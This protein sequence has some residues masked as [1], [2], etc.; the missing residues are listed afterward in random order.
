MTKKIAIYRGEG[1]WYQGTVPGMAL[2]A[3]E[4][5]EG[6]WDR[7]AS[8]FIMPGGRDRL[9]HADL[10]GPGNQKIRSFVEKGGT[11]LGI[12][13]GA[14]YGCKKI[15]F[16]RDSPLEICEERELSFFSGTA[17][18]PAYGTGT[19]VYGCRKGV[20]A[21]LIDSDLGSFHSYHY[22]GCYFSGD[23]SSCRVLARYMEIPGHP[24]AVIECSVGKGKAI[25]SGVH[26]EISDESGDPQDPHFSSIA[27]FLQR[28]EK[29]RIKFWK[30]FILTENRWQ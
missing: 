27:P 24:P 23:F 20:R 10:K 9:Y 19:Y 30:K 14:Y 13:A 7:S 11:Y 16:E 25:L 21:S 29:H 18:G 2:S 1:T 15:D 17:I 26:L 3:Q 6:D 5:I 12:C 22:G 28:S 8:L 4:T